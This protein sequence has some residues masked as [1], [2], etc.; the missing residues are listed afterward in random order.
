[1]REFS[2]DCIRRADIFAENREAAHS[3]HVCTAVD[4]GSLRLS[5]D[6]AWYFHYALRPEET[7]HGFQKPEMDCR[8]WPTIQV[9]G[10]IQL[11]GYGRPQ[12]VNVQYPWDGWQEVKTGSAPETYNPVGSYVK[13][14]TLP[15]H[16]AGRQVFISFQGAESALAVW[17][18]G[19]YVGYGED[20]F[21]PSEFD[22]TPYLQSGENKLAVQVFQW[23]AASWYEDQDFFRFSGIFREV[24]LYTV[25]EVHIWDLKLTA[26]FA[27]DYQ[28]AALEIAT[29]VTGGGMAEYTLSFHGQRIAAAK[30]TAGETLTL[31]VHQPA[32]WSAEAPNLYDLEI[33]VFAEDGR[34][35]ERV[36]HPVGFRH[37]VI[38]NGLMKLNGK[39]LLLRGVNR[40]EFSARRGRAVTEEEMLQDILTMKRNN[41]NAVRT[42]HYPNQTAF[43]RLCDQYGIYVMDEMNVESHGC[44]A[45]MMLGNL[46]LEEHIPGDAPVWGAPVVQRAEAMYQRDKNHPCVLIWSCGNESYGGRNFQAVS[47]YFHRVDDRPVHYE[48]ASADSRYPN[49]SDIRSNMYAPAEEIREQ[50]AKDSSKPAISCEYGHAMGNSFG[51]QK[52][53]ID[54]VNE[55]PAYQ[56][57]FIWDYIDQALTW[58]DA[59]GREYQA[60]GGDFGDRPH[61]GNFCGDGLV[62]S[63]DRM[64]SPKMAEVKALYQNL[65]ANIGDRTVTITNRYLFTDSDAFQC[66][67][68]LYRQGVLQGEACLET[69]VPPQG[70]KTYPLPLWP[71][72]LDGEYSV[73]V[74]FHLLTDTAWAAAGYEVAFGQRVLGAPVYRQEHEEALEVVDG[75]WN[76]G[77]HGKD[78][79]L[80]FSKDKGGLIS[81]RRAGKELLRAMPKPNFW[82]APTDNDR[83]WGMPRLC[84]SWKL[85]SLYQQYT[86]WK[87][88]RRD[89]SVCVSFAME[90]P[91][92]PKTACLLTYTVLPSGWVEA[93][94]SCDTRPVEDILPEFGMNFF[95]EPDASCVRWYGLGPEETYCDRNHGCKLGIYENRVGDDLPGYLKP[96]ECG[97]HTATRWASITDEAG[98]G[99]L[100]AGDNMEFSALPYT[101]HELENAGHMQELPQPYQTVITLASKKMGVGADQSWGA[102]PRPEY[103]LEK[104]AYTF[105][106]SFR[107]IG[108]K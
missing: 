39:R 7:I 2:L 41:I 44:W 63:S 69:H 104:G 58:K 11:Q 34:A 50:L 87:L 83:G 86:G 96:Q 19:C 25:P 57:G 66:R 92:A 3:D 13:Y 38:Q 90:L 49:T 45:Q 52:R 31:H 26:A 48:G 60:Y 98:V 100:F 99:L 4:G 70:E 30:G 65:E 88:E 81:C 62:Y 54:L 101:S 36:C 53:Y 23:T 74:S 71:E 106:F 14:F 27:G 15:E 79:H 84:G 94:L 89:G 46:K 5:L 35:V 1:M 10:H 6:G 82:R 68:R 22:L 77:V 16:M 107:A 80:L 95:L 40:H 93:A 91:T 76:I 85:A 18:N 72:T 56:G 102:R 64:P 28:E 61:D 51:G 8:R 37:F 21:T 59:L 43:Y 47:D 73:V 9:P 24:Y 42:S 103:F 32:L 55:V 17:L 105:R 33:I 29:R 12:Y 108:G 78:F 20:A 75:G 67:V 97:N